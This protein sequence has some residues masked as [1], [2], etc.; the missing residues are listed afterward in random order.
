MEHTIESLLK[1]YNGYVLI[2]KNNETEV[3]Q[4]SIVSKEFHDILILE[5][6]NNA[7][8]IVN[9][10]LKQGIEVFESFIEFSEKYPA[11][12]NEERLAKSRVYWWENINKEKWPNEISN[13]FENNTYWIEFR[14]RNNL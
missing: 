7:L 10:W 4:Y 9:T 13:Y 5:D 1:D 12:S 6:Y 8:F 11:P 14:K 3:L 2:K